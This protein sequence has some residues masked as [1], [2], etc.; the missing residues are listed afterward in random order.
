MQDRN[1][2]NLLEYCQY[3]FYKGNDEWVFSEKG[4]C[5]NILK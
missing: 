4:P 2:N 1:R 3:N 5:H